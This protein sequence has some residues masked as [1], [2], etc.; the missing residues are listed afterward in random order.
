M[1]YLRKMIEL[2][3]PVNCSSVLFLLGYMAPGVETIWEY[4]ILQGFTLTEIRWSRSGDQL[5][6]VS[7]PT[8]KLVSRIR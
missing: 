2:W 5:Q 8:E 4:L 6:K 7:R 3:V 1:A